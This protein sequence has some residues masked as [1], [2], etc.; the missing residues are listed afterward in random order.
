MV[1]KPDTVL[2]L[3]NLK[4]VYRVKNLQGTLA[5]CLFVFLMFLLVSVILSGDQEQGACNL[6]GLVHFQN[7][8]FLII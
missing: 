5:S 6:K 4:S 3:K 8:H 1:Q 7:K 2:L